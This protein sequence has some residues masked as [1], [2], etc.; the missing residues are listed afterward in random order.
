MGDKR[1]ALV[2]AGGGARGAYE[3]GALSV[4][5]PELER[6][7]ERPTVYLGASVGTLNAAVLASR[8][9][10]GAEAQAQ[11]VL[12]IWRS[13]DL[14][15]VITPILRKAPIDA[16]FGLGQM[17]SIPGMKLRSLLDNSPLHENVEKWVDWEGLRSGI[18]E[19]GID[20]LCV[21]ATSAKTGKTVVFVDSKEEMA[22]HRSHDVAYA[23]CKMGMEHIKASGALPVIWPPERV[24]NP[25]RVR[26]WYFDGGVR[27]NAPIKPALDLGADQL[28]VMAIDSIEGPVLAPDAERED[29]EPDMGVGLLQLLE[30]TLTDPLI[31]DMRKL[32]NVNEYL[33]GD[34]SIG[35]RMYRTVRGKPP[36]KEVPYV[37]IG[38]QERGVIGRLASEVFDRRYSGL[39]WLRNPEY[40]LISRLLGGSGPVHGELLSLLFF[41]EKFIELLLQLGAEDA[42]TWLEADHDGD[43]PWQIAALS[44]FTRPRQWTAG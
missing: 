22:F 21:T 38:P 30:G 34:N 9:D 26:G 19:G 42:R 12:D 6:R 1:I 41:D 23:A 2:I 43:G 40:R 8:H 24:E 36:Y 4:I 14:G 20:A 27:A 11:Q 37:F 13:I 17:L 10:Q 15:D 16:F 32:G 5:L 28:V 7:G 35:S 33:A 18:D 29:D 44:S 3:A 31:E 25:P 39:K